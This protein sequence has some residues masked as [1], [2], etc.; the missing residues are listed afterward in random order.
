[1]QN[2]GCC[3]EPVNDWHHS[4]K[5]LIKFISLNESTP[6]RP[7]SQYGQYLLSTKSRSSIESLTIETEPE[8][9]H[10]WDDSTDVMEF[11][12]P[13]NIHSI[14]QNNSVVNEDHKLRNNHKYQRE[15]WGSRPMKPNRRRVE[16]SRH[17]ISSGQNENE[18]WSSS[19]WR[20][21]S[22]GAP[23]QNEADTDNADYCTIVHWS[24]GDDK[25]NK[26]S[27]LSINSR[28]VSYDGVALSSF[29]QN[30]RNASVKSVRKTF[31][32]SSGGVETNRI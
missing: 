8:K 2:S 1:M 11:C 4:T 7:S 15:L 17:E 20:L 30:Q 10:F 18:N 5:D 22:D 31:S 3:Y 23:S 13:Y 21:E 27:A 32:I 26:S 25:L 29:S 28:K 24:L 16:C 6:T 19:D 12:R 9:F 14:H